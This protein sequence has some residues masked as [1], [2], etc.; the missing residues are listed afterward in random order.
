MKLKIFLTFLVCSLLIQ[1]QEFKKTATAGFVFLEMPVTARSAALGDAS[2]SLSDLNSDAVFSNPAALGFINQQ[3]MLSVS[4]SPWIADIKHYAA[5]YSYTASYGVIGVGVNFLDY[6]SFPRTRKTGS[7]DVYVVDGTFSANDIAIGVSY[8]KM[9]T[10][11]FSFGVTGKYVKET[12]DIYNASNFLFDGGILYYTGL[13]SLRIAAAIQNFGVNSK[14]K[15]EEFKM[16]IAL[17]LGAAAE[18]YGSYNSD[19]RITALA[20]ALHPNDGDER[21][22]LGLETSWRNI[23]TL[24]GGYKF[25]YDEETYNFGVGINPKLSYPVNVDFSYS[26]YGRLGNIVRFTLQLG[27]I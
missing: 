6:G 20:E 21:L 24:R 11:R 7:K 4:Y 17:K 14:F 22:I 19:Y 9:L 2:I 18:V 16:P 3:N 27:L 26:N 15:K 25:F 8:S 1:A 23:I 12:I 13:S 10:D 5:S